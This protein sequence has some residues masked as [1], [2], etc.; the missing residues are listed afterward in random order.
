M[1]K[2]T[3][4]LTVTIRT[5]NVGQAFGC[6]GQIVARNGRVVATTRTYPYGQHSN[7]YEAAASL[8][9]KLGHT[10]ANSGNG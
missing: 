3:E 7:A 4:P 8:A 9:A 5:R 2:P 10:V 1:T 6:E